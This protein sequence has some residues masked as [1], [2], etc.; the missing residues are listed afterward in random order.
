MK[1]PLLDEK[2]VKKR[3]QDRYYKKGY[4]AAKKGLSKFDDNPYPIPDDIRKLIKKRTAW[5]I[6]FEEFDLSKDGH[7]QR[8]KQTKKSDVKVYDISHLKSSGKW[9]DKKKHDRKHS[10]NNRRKDR[11]KNR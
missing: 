11:H 9:K 7:K 6:G 2:V 5:L 10:R 4:R 8:G 3:L 1:N